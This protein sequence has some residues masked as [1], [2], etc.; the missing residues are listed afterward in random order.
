MPNI[1]KRLIAVVAIPIV[2]IA[3]ALPIAL[4]VV[5][6]SDG[7]DIGG[8]NSNP[9]LP[10]E[11]TVVA[12]EQPPL[13]ANATRIRMINTEFVPNETEIDAGT[14]IAFLNEDNSQHTATVQ[15]TTADVDE[16]FDSDAIDPRGQ[17]V[18]EPQAPGEY[19]L[20]CTIHPNLMNLTVRVR[21]AAGG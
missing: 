14:A 15:D 17:V 18:W 1:S 11:S 3:I 21:P 4:V 19:Q 8:E 13:P 9:P 6:D 20:I 2:F 5:S 10:A 12:G 7:E 16:R